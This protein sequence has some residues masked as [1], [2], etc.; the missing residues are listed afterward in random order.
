MAY[1]LQP[2]ITILQ[3]LLN[4]EQKRWILDHNKPQLQSL[5]EK[6]ASLKQILENSPLPKAE[7]S[8][9]SQIRDAAHEAEDII[10]SHMVD[11]MLSKPGDASLAF[12]T[13]DL[14]QVMQKLDSVME[15]V[16]ASQELVSGVEEVLQL[17]PDGTS[18]SGASPLQD[19]SWK[20]IVVGVDEDLM[21]L[22][23]RL[24]GTQSKLEIVPIVGMGG[25]GK[26]TLARQLYR[27]PLI[28]EHFSSLAWVTISQDYDMRAILLGLL[29]C[30]IGKEIDQH[31]ENKNSSLK[32]ILYQSLF[33]RKY[34]IV[35]DDIWS[36]I[37]WD[38]IRKYFPDNNNG[39]RIVITTRESVVAKHVSSQSKQH[40]MQL[41]NGSKSWNLLRQEVFEE[42][43]D[44]PAALER[45]GRNIASNCGG[46]PLAIHV[47]GGLLSKANR[48]RDLWENVAN[49]VSAV[50]AQSGE[51]FSNILSLS[52]NHLP[53][54]LRPCFLYMGAFP[55]DYEIKP[56]R[57]IRLWVA[58]G[59]LRSN[60]DKSME[61]EAEDCL[62]ALV[63]RNLVSVRAFKSTGRPKRYGIHDLMRDLCLKKG[64]EQGFVHVK[65]KR[66]GMV[67][68]DSVYS[69]R[70]VSVHPSYR[71]GDVYASAELMSFARSF[72]C[73][74][75]ASREILSSVFF[76]L[77]LLRVLDILEIKFP[78]FPTEILHILNLHYLAFSCNVEVLPSYISRLCNLQT[79][80]ICTSLAYIDLPAEIWQM[81]ELRHVKFG[82]AY[83]SGV[84][85]SD[86]ILEK[87]QTISS[88]GFPSVKFL[89]RIPNIKYLGIT[90][91]RCSDLFHLHKLETLKFSCFRGDPRVSISGLRL[92]PSVR[93]LSLTR[94]EIA[95]EFM[96]YLSEELPNLEVLKLRDCKFKGLWDAEQQEFS[97]LQFLL[98][99]QVQLVHWQADES[100]FPRLRHLVIRRCSALEEIPSG[101]GDILTLQ[102]IELDECSPSVVA[103]ATLIIEEQRANGNDDLQL[104]M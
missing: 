34:F 32:D 79:L 47:V 2:L 54:H 89:G 39:S 93:N 74:G 33:G 31:I 46:L 52:Y 60:G 75:L 61:E 88:I 21:L 57:L 16:V 38:E 95:V 63:A 70:R 82:G 3:Q 101:I 22:K 28:V 6:S 83:I 4:P 20:S 98:L 77:R 48:A 12:L 68:K 76:C 27:D 23:D 96:E 72:V 56:S 62:N 78:Q 65:K 8:L 44:C 10:E 87:L 13:P 45:I 5:L 9:E 41:L 86:W 100:S 25:I 92:P 102:T 43:E 42:E 80:V 1:N 59:F 90:S 84:G 26:T 99:E 19:P 73:T 11:R 91:S 17:L 37:F 104:R 103:S 29:R 15:Q 35:L 94:C 24:T 66:V 58:E 30:I 97:K 14:Q 81:T 40:E 51:Q 67:N 64:E 55:E 7:T 53:S 85:Y 50:V 18:S 49:D 36:N 69:L 71:I